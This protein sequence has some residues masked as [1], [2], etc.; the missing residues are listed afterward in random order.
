MDLLVRWSKE[1]QKGLNISSRLQ[2]PTN[3]DAIMKDHWERLNIALSL[4]ADE[5]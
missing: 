2:I 5:L 3:I 1:T 4:V